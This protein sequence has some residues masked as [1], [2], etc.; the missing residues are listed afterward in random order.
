MVAEICLMI[1]YALLLIA[2]I[3]QTRV[4]NS[5]S[6][7]SLDLHDPEVMIMR[8]LFSSMYYLVPGL[9]YFTKKMASTSKVE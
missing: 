9:S 4:K 3:Y 6:R 5:N 2:F 7:M 1:L 8:N